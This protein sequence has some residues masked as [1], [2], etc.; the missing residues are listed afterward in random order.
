MSA[1]IINVLNYICDKIG[2]AIDWTADN[3]WPQVMDILGRYRILM[4]IN[5][6]TCIIF[7]IIA[8]ITF[9]VLWKKAIKAHKTALKERT[10][11]FWWHYY[12]D[13]SVGQDGA[14]GL[15]MASMFA[16]IIVL[17]VFGFSFSSFFRWLLV[18]EIKYLEMLKT[19]IQ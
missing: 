10:S 1:E 15:M 9:V 2:I 11:N 12:R 14:F 19:Y 18:P 7:A 17:L 13:G 6:A 16:G 3:I 4:L 8:I 5:N